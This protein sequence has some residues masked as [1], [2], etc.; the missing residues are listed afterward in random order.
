VKIIADIKEKP[1]SKIILEI[2][3]RVKG[4]LVDS[5]GYINGILYHLDQ[6]V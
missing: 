6:K 2:G 1:T 5:K 4:E 3:S